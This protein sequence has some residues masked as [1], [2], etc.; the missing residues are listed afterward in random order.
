MREYLDQR[1]GRIK[2]RRE[3][4]KHARVARTRRQVL[5]YGFL[6]S[7]MFIGIAGFIRV[8]WSVVDPETD[9]KV[10]GNSV[11]TAKQVRHSL[12]PF[13]HKPIYSLDP[14][15]LEAKLQTLP[16]VQKAFVR[17][18]LFPRPHLV[19]DVMEEFPWAT[20]SPAPDQPATAVIS[21]TGRMV[22]IA[23]FPSVPQPAL[24]IY[25]TSHT[26]FSE[27]EVALWA[28]WVNFIST[29]TATAVDYVDLRKPSDIQVHC[30][31]LHLRLGSADSLL[32]K[33]LA[34][35]PS[36]LPILANLTKENI[37]YVDLSLD[38]NVPL[39]VSK[40]PKKQVLNI[41]ASVVTSASAPSVERSVRASTVTHGVNSNAGSEVGNSSIAGT[42]TPPM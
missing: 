34:R 30:G 29:Q 24:K 11:V 15:A 35:L 21:Q 6:V 32:S 18:Y 10:F 19:V 36:V 25:G 1:E 17:R 41:P 26:H 31:D 33:R 27:N 40:E 12:L 9:I 16:D 23:Q 42:G 13:L 14:K 22:P 28:N 5:R 4:R 39:K 2:G 3:K 8:S 38:S 7:L 37:E 20:F